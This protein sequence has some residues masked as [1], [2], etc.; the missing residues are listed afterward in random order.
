MDNKQF[1]NEESTDDLTIKQEREIEK[2]VI[3]KRK[4]KLCAI[5]INIFCCCSD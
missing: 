5:H 4:K 1:K 2:E 3:L